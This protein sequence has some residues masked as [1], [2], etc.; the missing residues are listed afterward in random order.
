MAVRKI[1]YTAYRNGIHPKTEQYAGIQNEHNATCISFTISDELKDDL[2]KEIDTTT[3]KFLYRY[4]LYDGAGGYHPS[5]PKELNL[6][7]NDIMEKYLAQDETEAGGQLQIYFIISKVPKDVQVEAAY[8]PEFTFYSSPGY[9]ILEPLLHGV[10]PTKKVASDLSLL[11]DKV[12]K[13]GQDLLKMKENGEFKGDTG[14]QGPQG[15]EGPQGPQG[16]Q[17]IQGPK[18]ETGEKGDKGDTYQL[19]DSDKT[20]IANTILEHFVNVA[21]VGQ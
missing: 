19:T 3:H 5:V 6:D 9:L 16:P 14:A 10:E 17:G 7:S 1:Y 15:I 8:N 21:E 2:K 18:G 13:I 12:S 4:D 11:I 20:D